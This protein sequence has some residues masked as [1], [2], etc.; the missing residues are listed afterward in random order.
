MSLPRQPGQALWARI[1]TLLAEEIGTGQI[2]SGDR[3]PTEPALMQRFGVSRATVR[4]ALA[5]LERRGLIHA[6]QGRGTFVGPRRLSYA[7]SE[8]TR[9]SRNLIE[10]GFEPSGRLLFERVVP[11]GPVVG[12][13]LAI[14]E[15]Q[16]V[17]HRHGIGEAD[18][19][20]IELADVYVPLD[21]FPGWAEV[22]ARHTTYTAAF[23]HYGVRDY[24]RLST[25]IEA[26]MPTQEEAALL[27]QP[28]TSPVFVMTRVDAD[29]D[30]RPIL[31]GHALWCADRVTFEIGG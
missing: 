5:S 26:R 31:Y 22:K 27:D 2:V 29:P 15:W 10:Q 20:P 23:A 8:R 4:Q 25:R 14:P 18:G 7:L 17:S 3:L 1:E 6:E 28:R 16:S 13:R 21:R 11:A 9:F 19:V 12:D 24:R 30:G